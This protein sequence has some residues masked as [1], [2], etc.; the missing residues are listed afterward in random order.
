MIYILHNNI[1]PQS[2]MNREFGFKELKVWERAIDFADYAISLSECLQTPMNHFRL[3]EQ[4]E[5]C[6]SSVAMNIAEGKGRYSDKEYI[7]FLYIAPGS[8]YEALTLSV[9]FNKRGWI[10]DEQLQRLH[11]EAYEI[12]RMIKGLINSLN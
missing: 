2:H 10:N 12:A 4:F 9:I 7:R 3:V 6:S 8:L 5:S 11:D 1:K